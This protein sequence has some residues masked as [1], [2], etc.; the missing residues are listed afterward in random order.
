[1]GA[2]GTPVWQAPAA[3]QIDPTSTHDGVSAMKTRRVIG[4]LLLA[5]LL[6]GAILRAKGPISLGSTLYRRFLPLIARSYAKPES[7]LPRYG[8][9][10]FLLVVNKAFEPHMTTGDFNGDG[11]DDIML[12]HMDFPGHRAFP[13]DVLLNDGRGSLRLGTQ[14]VF[15][16]P[17]PEVNA[18]A[19][20]MEVADFN[21]DGV[22]DFFVAD[23]G[24]DAP[25]FPGGQNKLVLSA[26]GGKLV[27]ATSQ[28]PQQPTFT[29]N[30]AAADVDG[31]GDVDLFLANT[32]TSNDP[33]IGPQI[34]LNDG[35][36]RFTIAQG[37]LPPYIT[38]LQ[39]TFWSCGKFTDVN[40]DRSPDLILGDTGD[41]ENEAT[42]LL[43]NGAGFFSPLSSAMP[44]KPWSKT[45]H[46]YDIQPAYIDG[47]AK[48]DLFL[49]YTRYDY[50]GQYIQVCINRGDGTFRDETA[51]RLPQADNYRPW[52]F[53]LLLRDMDLDGDQDLIARYWTDWDPDPLLYLNDGAGHYQQY[54]LEL[55]MWL[56][57]TF[58][59]VDND[60]RLDLA[61]STYAQTP[62]EEIYLIRNLGCP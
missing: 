35:Q 49:A 40:G 24:L 27:D 4:S 13:M 26:P 31:D 20:R 14:E 8:Q 59:D 50:R 46:L 7:C 55:D 21:G 22:D 56:Y 54:P 15:L 51:Q 43:N 48:I 37:R 57:H 19:A 6:L 17:V 5:F 2:A 61:F 36:G 28:L 58:L 60:Q 12:L 9:P 62:P 29:H 42:V 41:Y 10:E 33:K 47:D 18:P 44:T 16:G 25:P 52:I 1:L 45:D 32:W 23:G 38:D 53:D 39:Q 34:L 3:S 11:W 30:A